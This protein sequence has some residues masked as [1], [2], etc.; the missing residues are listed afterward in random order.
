MKWTVPIKIY[1]KGEIKDEVLSKWKRAYA[2]LSSISGINVSYT[3]NIRDAN[4]VIVI[5]DNIF[6]EQIVYKAVINKILKLSDADYNNEAHRIAKAGGSSVTILPAKNSFY[7]ALAIVNKSIILSE[8]QQDGLI[9]WVAFSSFVNGASSNIVQPSVVNNSTAL[10]K[11][12]NI[13]IAIVKA[14]YN[15]KIPYFDK[16]EDGIPKI[17][18]MM[19]DS[20]S[21]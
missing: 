1:F 4:V 7:L 6:E 19:R 12:S 21:K 10:V 18:E 8:N 13:D 20:L 14:L 15:N 3:D 17:A 5:T 9:N 16:K 11:W 2:D